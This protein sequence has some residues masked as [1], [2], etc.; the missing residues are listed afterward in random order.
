MTLVCIGCKHN[1]TYINNYLRSAFLCAP[2]RQT[3]DWL[4]A[5]F[6]RR[7][8]A[9]AVRQWIDASHGTPY[10][11]ES[12]SNISSRKQSISN[13][14]GNAETRVLTLRTWCIRNFLSSL[15]LKISA[16]QCAVSSST[17][18]SHTLSRLNLG[19]P[20]F[21][22]NYSNTIWRMAR[23][24]HISPITAPVWFSSRHDLA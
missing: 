15:P 10:M 21:N 4:Y 12:S 18:R 8:W 9:Y 1:L 7:R 6:Y 2:S 11:Q 17:C 13:Q 16:F 20:R 19:K 23:S 24:P 22:I 5:E 14:K 3:H